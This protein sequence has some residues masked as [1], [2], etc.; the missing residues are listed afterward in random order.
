MQVRLAQ[1]VA[2]QIR[3]SI[4]DTGLGAGEKLP[5]EST[6]MERHSVSRSTI[7][8]AMKILQAENIVEIRHGRGSFVAAKTGLS[9]DPLGFSFADPARLLP[10][11][12]EVRLLMEPSI[13]EIA[14]ARRNQDDL[15]EM[16]EAIQQ[17]I[18][19]QSRGED[20][21][22]SD[23]RFH[24]AVAE[25][26]HNAVLD[27]IFPVLLEGIE[28]GYAQT[29]H[30]EGSFDRAVD[31]HRRILQAIREGD[32]AEASCLTQMHIRQTLRDIREKLKG[33]SS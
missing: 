21:H 14:A 9:K 10:D 1:V 30:I 17:M 5:T 3:D 2:E 12:M 29:V 26:T 8:E 33:E 11:L 19:K 23:Y 7:R 27:R 25:A 22:T 31:Y 18:E 16:E 6:L 28:K 24:L 32:G 20:Y 13:A 4:I 15:A